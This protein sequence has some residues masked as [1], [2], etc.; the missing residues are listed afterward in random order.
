[1]T[2]ARYNNFKK[3]INMKKIYTVLFLISLC[4][5]KINAQSFS[6]QSINNYVLGVADSFQYELTAEIVNNSSSSKTVNMRKAINDLATGHTSLFCWGINCYGEATDTSTYPESMPS[7]G[8][9]LA[10]ADGRTYFFPGLSKVT[11]CWYDVN[12]PAD[13]LCLEF[14]YDIGT[15]GIHEAYNSSTDFISL[16][17]PNPADGSTTIVYHL[18]QKNGESKVVFYNVIGSKMQE[19]K[20]DDS[21]Q[22][23]QLNTSAFQPGVYYYSLISGG[24]A[25]STNKLIVSHKN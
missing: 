4:S 12:N 24:K 19:V 11:Y 25:I 15:T 1:L 18:N 14:I 16:P 9:S 8:V 2:F 5:V 6:L 7:G 10:R 20:L 13:S 21:K 3:E 22:S 23:I 17:Q